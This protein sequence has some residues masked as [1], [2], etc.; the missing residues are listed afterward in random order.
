M[1]TLLL[2]RGLHIGFIAIL[3]G[4]ISKSL[5]SFAKFYKT[6]VVVPGSFENC[7][8]SKEQSIPAMNDFRC[9]SEYFHNS[10]RRGGRLI[11]SL[12]M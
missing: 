4:K 9:E 6:P 5:T 10:F 11:N 1:P 12:A 2:I 3:I 8:V 7:S